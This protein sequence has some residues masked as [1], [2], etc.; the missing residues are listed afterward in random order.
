MIF[1]LNNEIP[2]FLGKNII[3]KEKEIK[4]FKNEVRPIALPDWPTSLLL[5]DWKFIY[6]LGLEKSLLLKQ[7]GR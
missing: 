2:N 5:N 3:F 4:D 7:S 6:S 1:R